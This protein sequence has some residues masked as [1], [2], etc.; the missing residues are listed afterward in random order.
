MNETFES[1]GNYINK[2]VSL[3]QEIRIIEMHRYTIDELESMPISE[4]IRIRQAL[5]RLKTGEEH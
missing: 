2:I 3:E 1:R 5:E 4:L